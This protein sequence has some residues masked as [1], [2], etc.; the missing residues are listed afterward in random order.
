VAKNS[1]FSQ[2][3]KFIPRS[4]FE[5]WVRELGS[6]KGVRRLDSWTWF[7]SLL[8]SQLSGHDSI[9]AIERVF[10]HSD[11]QM[12]SM[13]FSS[14]RRSTLADANHSRSLELLERVFG[15]CLERVKGLPRKHGFRFK[16]EVLAL[17]STFIRLCL[18]LCPWAMYRRSPRGNNRGEF[19]KSAGIK[20]HTAIDLA[21][22]IPDFVVL[23]EGTERENHDLRVAKMLYEPRSGST[24][25]MDRGYWEVAWFAKFTECRAYFVTR[26]ARRV[27]F[28]VAKS[29]VV[30]RTQGLIC[31]QEIYLTG[32]KTQEDYRGKLRRVGFRDPDTG[33]KLVFITNRFDLAAKTICDLYRARWRVE[34]FFRCIKQNLKIKK[35]L[36][37]SPQAVK[38][39]VWVALIAYLVI[40]QLRLT[41]RSSISMP[42]A[43]AVIGTLLLLRIPLNV[44]LGRLPL[45]RRHPPPLQL[46]LNF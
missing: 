35:F 39:Q 14:V 25:I 6:D 5:G 15:Y 3:I 23:K 44:I 22:E 43:M 11:K 16:G 38:A 37:F 28:R 26:I 32:R 27:G 19:V 2:V 30:D 29:N 13:G 4:R 8:F 41:L 12:R 18:S 1:V 20:M 34:L 33:K 40:Q 21:G 9:R 10:A 7:G 31:D 46:M 36:G 17:D 42:D 24:T 45:V